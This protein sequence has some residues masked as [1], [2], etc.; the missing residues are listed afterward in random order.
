MPDA[1][2]RLFH[3]YLAASARAGSRIALDQLAQQFQ[4]RLLAHARRLTGSADAAQ[5]VVQ[6]SWLEIVRGLPRLDDSAAFP[7]WAFRIVSR[8]C[9]KWIRRMQRQRQLDAQLAAEALDPP[10]QN[11]G[12]QTADAQRVRQAIAALPHDQRAAIAL[13]YLEDMTVA[14]IAIALNTPAG[15]VKTRLMHARDKIRRSLDLKEKVD[16]RAG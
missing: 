3:E 5:D 6:E 13:F 16:E 4:P 2:Q 1:T 9:A 11:E 8:R 15:T 7:A 12:E 14:E 10:Q